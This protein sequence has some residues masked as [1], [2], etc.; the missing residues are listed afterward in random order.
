MVLMI[1]FILTSNLKYIDISSL[2]SI[3]P[4]FNNVFLL[5]VPDNGVIIANSKLRGRI[6]VDNWKIIYK[7]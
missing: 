5:D 6:F 1:C 4:E 2:Y 7:D 3:Y